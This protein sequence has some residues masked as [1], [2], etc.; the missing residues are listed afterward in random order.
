MVQIPCPNPSS[1]LFKYVSTQRAGGIDT[2][3]VMWCGE[4]VW[5]AVELSSSSQTDNLLL[6]NQL[7]CEGVDFGLEVI[8]RLSGHVQPLHYSPCAY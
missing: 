6:C 1:K 8:Q 4:E 2:H 3:S 7:L 5:I